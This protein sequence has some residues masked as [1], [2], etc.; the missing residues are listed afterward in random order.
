MEGR[1]PIGVED[2]D[3]MQEVIPVM[4]TPKMK[5]SKR[6]VHRAE[7]II[8]KKNAPVLMEED[9]K[10]DIWH[11]IS[12]H[13]VHSSVPDEEPLWKKLVEYLETMQQQKPAEKNPPAAAA[14]TITADDPEQE[15][16]QHIEKYI[17]YLHKKIRKQRLALKKLAKYKAFHKKYSP[18][19]QT[20]K[21]HTKRDKGSTFNS[22]T[23]SSA[24]I[25]PTPPQPQACLIQFFTPC[26]KVKS[27]N[28]TDPPAGNNNNA[29][30]TPSPNEK[31]SDSGPLFNLA[32]SEE[33]LD[34]LLSEEDYDPFW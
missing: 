3:A 30:M 5:G 17:R 13:Q 20:N 26:S 6:Y 18:L 4:Q 27:S 28:D 2:K 1:G 9:V 29:M 11:S 21:R 8:L 33:Q 24:A 34:P 16:W 12:P 23:T 10:N 25:L 19:I 32:Y 31:Y 14:A 15:L 22:T 7:R